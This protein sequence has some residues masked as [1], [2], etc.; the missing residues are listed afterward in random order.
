MSSLIKVQLYKT[1]IP[2]SLDSEFSQTGLNF[3]KE[4]VKSCFG[5]SA[6]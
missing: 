5:F 2:L 4:K 3:I 6:C 1:E